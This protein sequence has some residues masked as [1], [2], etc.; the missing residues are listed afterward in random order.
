L[1]NLLSTRTKIWSSA[2]DIAKMSL[3]LVLAVH[4]VLA[5][6]KFQNFQP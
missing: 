1:E 2:E 5:V 4:L 6:W 3:D